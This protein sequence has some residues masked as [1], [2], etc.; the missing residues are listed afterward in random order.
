MCYNPVKIDCKSG[1]I[2]VNCGQC[3]Q[4]RKQR[5]TDIE[6]LAVSMMQNSD[7]C[8]GWFITFTY[9][10]QHM[11]LTKDGFPTAVKKEFQNCIKALKMRLLRHYDCEFKYVYC[12]EY[13]PQN[14]RP[15]YHSIFFFNKDL[16]LSWKQFKELIEEYWI[17]GF[18]KVEPLKCTGG[19][20]YITKYLQ[21]DF[22]Y[23]KDK[24]LEI[25]EL[26]GD[27]LQKYNYDSLKNGY[28]NRNVARNLLKVA[29]IVLPEVRRTNNL[30]NFTSVSIV[31]DKLKCM[32]YVIETI[33]PFDLSR[34]EKKE[35][36][37]ADKLFHTNFFWESWLKERKVDVYKDK[38][39]FV[40]LK[41]IKQDGTIYS[42]RYYLTSYLYKRLFGATALNMR[43]IY[44]LG[45][46]DLDRTSQVRRLKYQ[47]KQANK[48]L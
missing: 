1:P 41:A 29:G 47:V 40:R 5:A 27:K 6:Y 28:L 2:M 33:V 19:V 24:L 15:H 14:A 36:I 10:D 25:A 17:Y 31:K 4:C 46:L 39:I 42:K 23:P 11:T 7:F 34:F 22:V 3:D 43:L 26:Y 8:H 30:H 35:I 48:M 13:T 21:K 18:T 45:F 9:D 32:N 44:S 37:H 20:N 16:G 12:L 38:L